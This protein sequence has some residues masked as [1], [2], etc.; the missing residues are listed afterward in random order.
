MSTIKKWL[1]LILC[2]AMCLTMLAACSH[3]AT[4]PE[5]SKTPVSDDAPAQNEAPE[6]TPEE[7]E[8]N[9]APE[10]TPEEAPEEQEIVEIEVWMNAGGSDISDWDKVLDAINAMTEEAVGVR[11]N[12]TRL[13]NAEYQNQLGLA[14]SGGTTIDLCQLM[15]L[16]AIKFSTMYNNGQLSDI[17]DALNL[18]GQDILATLGDYIDASTVGGRI[19]A[20]PNYRLYNTNIY[21]LMRQDVLE[22]LGLTDQ[23]MNMKTF[24]EMEALYQAVTNSDLNLYATGNMNTI[25][26]NEGVM[27]NSDNF[28][29]TYPYDYLE[30]LKLC[31]TDDEGHVSSVLEQEDYIWMLQKAAD[32]MQAGYVYPDSAIDTDGGD[33]LIKQNV[34]FSEIGGSQLGVEANKSGIIGYELSAVKLGSMIVGTDVIDNWSFAVPATAEEPEAA[35]KWYNY[36]YNNPEILNMVAWGLEDEH[37]VYTE[38]GEAAYPEGAAADTVTY[39]YSDWTFGNQFLVAPWEGSSGDLR[40]LAAEDLAQSTKSPYLGFSLE[41]ESLSSIIASLSAV[42]GEYANALRC[43]LYT[44][45]ML[46][47][48]KAKLDAAG[49]NDYIAEIQAQ[50]DTWLESK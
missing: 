19:Y 14:I 24:T 45:S 11:A 37:V 44:E 20:I 28:A 23:A 36:C 40:T 46:E 1:A 17:T 38:N 13:Q 30:A 10:D 50:L 21:I 35:I 3:K 31:Y 42:E 15:P 29:D 41:T 16:N 6:E 25:L 32:W 43:G 5:D 27:F 18:Y 48:Y 39:H 4:T 33:M 47:E 26:A 9:E 7:T 49:L 12:F 22:E 8:G 2:V 34:I